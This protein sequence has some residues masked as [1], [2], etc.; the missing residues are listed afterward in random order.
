MAHT[1]RARVVNDSA[2][3]VAT[4]LLRLYIENNNRFQRY[5]F[6]AVVRSGPMCSSNQDTTR[7]A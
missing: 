1:G 3:P 2:L 5:F 7:A 4:I 6:E